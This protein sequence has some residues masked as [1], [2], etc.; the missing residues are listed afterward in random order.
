M[1]QST[2][3]RLKAQP[4]NAIFALDIGTRSIIG[5]V[6]TMENGRF[7]VIAMEKENQ[8]QRSM[9]DGQIEN[10]DEVVKIA[11]VVKNRLED[12][13]RCRLRRVCVA[14]AGRTLKT[15]R[16][17][18]EM[19]F[20]Q[21]QRVDEETISRLQAGAIA[22][23]EAVFTNG[24]DGDTRQFYLV[25]HSI[26]QYYMDSY[27]ISNLLDHQASQIQADVIATFLPREVVES[28]YLAMQRIDL[29]VES[30]TLEPIAAINAVI[31]NNLR[32]LNLALADIGAGTSDIAICKDGGI[33]GY[34]MATVAGDEIT[35]AL[36]K[37]YL[38]DFDTAESIKTQLGTQ[39]SVSITDILGNE[40]RITQQDMMDCIDDATED[41][42][43]EIAKHIC[44][45]NGAP[46][47]AVFLAGGGSKLASLR[48]GISKHMNIDIE[49]VA[50]AGNYF[51]TLAFSDIYDLNDPE[52][53]TPLGICISAGMNLIA[54]SFNITLNG[55]RAKLFRNGTMTIMDILM[56]NGYSS[57]DLLPQAGKKLIIDVNGEPKIFYGA[58]GE[59]AVLKLNGKDAKISDPV[60]TGDGIEFIPAVH[61]QPARRCLNDLLAD[62]PDQVA[63]VNGKIVTP[64]T[65]LK[66]GDVIV[67]TSSP[68]LPETAVKSDSPM[69]FE[70][71]APRPEPPVPAQS[72]GKIEFTLN[73]NPVL[74]SKKPD[75]TPY[76]VID[77]LELSGIDLENPTG[78]IVLR[79]NGAEGTFLTDLKHGDRLEIYYAESGSR[80]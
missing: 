28:L 78:E 24:M 53:A 18:F 47:S 52:Y 57:H 29:E 33:V 10:I 23:A 39:D 6:G 30:L 32:L 65:P 3:R 69:F 73:N 17:S 21:P 7:R 71:A 58:P 64:D 44:A 55:N 36:M 4:N 27:P 70:P 54:D 20:S 38:L 8:T 31:P 59:V 35:E 51:K 46:T 11:R 9:V 80:N 26:V 75:G 68:A 67:I 19:E 13:L 41:L 49:R 5:I 37:R 34:T 56:M 50:I 14:A 43:R 74:L 48:A 62:D 66:T 77:M 60:K 72:A 1:P 45:V 2:K 16:A 12:K 63:T 25:G 76:Y 40:H 42:C 79:V 15:Q 22:E 61:G